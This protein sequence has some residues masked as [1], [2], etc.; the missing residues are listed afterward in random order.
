MSFDFS[1]FHVIIPG[2]TSRSLSELRITTKT[3]SFSMLTAAELG[4]PEKVNILASPDGIQL[5]LCA[6]NQAVEY[7]KAA[8][9]FCKRDLNR[10]KK[11]ISIRAPSFVKLLRKEFSWQDSQARKVYGSIFR[12][13]G[14]IV[15]DLTKAFLP[16]EKKEKYLPQLADYPTLNEVQST[17]RPCILA[18]P[19]RS[20]V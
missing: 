3:L 7:D 20:C 19:E 15:F 6:A 18:L 8:V 1:N 16:G 17:Y 11:T 4:Y 5:V 12:Q 9:P 2:N 10:A 13:E 14:L